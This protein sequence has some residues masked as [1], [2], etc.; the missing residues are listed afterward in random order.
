MLTIYDLLTVEEKKKTKHIYSKK[1]SIIFS[2]S[3]LCEGVCICLSGIIKITSYS[4]NG[5]EIIYNT[6]IPGEMFGNNLIFSS[7]PFYKGNV[8]SK[9]NSTI[10]FINKTELLSILQSNKMFLEQYLK[11]HNEFSQHLNDR[12]KILSYNHAQERL[13]YLFYINNNTIKFNSIASL[14]DLLGLSREATSRMIATLSKK[15]KIKREGHT[16]TLFK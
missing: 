7:K 11:K 4:F 10:A 5:N 9:T 12:I 6:I 2:E 13:N 3:S 8:I 14:A 16:L 15:G 1:D